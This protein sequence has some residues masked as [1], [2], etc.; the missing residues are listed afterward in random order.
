MKPNR[1]VAWSHFLA[2]M[3]HYLRRNRVTFICAS[4]KD[5]SPR[6]VCY[7]I[8]LWEREV[9]GRCPLCPPAPNA[10][11]IA[12]IREARL[13]N[14]E[15]VTLETLGEVFRTDTPGTSSE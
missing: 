5:R 6:V 9:M 15:S 10:D 7:P 1:T 14:L 4:W 13:G 2:H 11:T 12:A 8:E 3:G